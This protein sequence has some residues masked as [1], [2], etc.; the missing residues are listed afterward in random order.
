MIVQTAYM[1]HR[2]EKEWKLWVEQRAFVALYITSHRGHLQAV[3]YLLEHG[4]T[5]AGEVE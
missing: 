4:S 2:G 3:K 1:Q 5:V